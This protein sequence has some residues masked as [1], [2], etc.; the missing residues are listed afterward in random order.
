[1]NGK[2]LGSDDNA[3]DPKLFLFDNEFM[4]E[5]EDNQSEN[6]SS[7]GGK[8]TLNPRLTYSKNSFQRLGRIRKKDSP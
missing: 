4:D 5:P 3:T 8:E 6:H 7:S 1:M 2:K